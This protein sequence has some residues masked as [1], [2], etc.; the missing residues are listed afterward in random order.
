[1]DKN[2]RLLIREWV[3]V[4][5]LTGLILSL[6]SISWITRIQE[7]RGFSSK[8]LSFS[9]ISTEIVISIEGAVEK[10]GIYQFPI[11]VSYQEILEKAVPAPEADRRRLKKKKNFY[12]SQTVFVPFKPKRSSLR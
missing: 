6:I 9:S 3:I 1:M 12:E 10:P 11:G 2:G 4:Y 5:L 8:T 7:E